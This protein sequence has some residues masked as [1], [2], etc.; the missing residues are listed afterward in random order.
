MYR[1]SQTIK[2][3][4]RRTIQSP[5]IPYITSVPLANRLSSAR[6]TVNYDVVLHL[7]RDGKKGEKGEVLVTKIDI[8]RREKVPFENA[9]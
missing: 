6:I 1:R 2:Y 9:V 5:H 3:A 4:F 7:N 8:E